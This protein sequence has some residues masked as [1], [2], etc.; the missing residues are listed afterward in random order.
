MTPTPVLVLAVA[1]FLQAPPSPTVLPPAAEHAVSAVSAVSAHPADPV[2]AIVAAFDSFR[3]VAVGENHGHREFHDLVLRLLEDSGAQAVVDDVAV[4]WGNAL[5]QP[6]VDRWVRGDDGVP[7]DSVTMAWRNTV[8]SPNTV[9]DAPVYE[10]F[11]REVRRINGSRDDGRS[12][13]V[14]LADSPVDWAAVDSAADLRPFF[15]RA[16]AMA[17][18]VRTESLR[19]GRRSLF[20]AGGLHVARVPRVRRTQQGVPVGEI[21]PVAWLELYHPGATWVVQ[22]MGAGARLDVPELVGS[23]PPA[24]V[25]LDAAP[26]LAAVVA[27]RTTTLRDR[28]GSRPDVYGALRLAD[29]VDAVLLWDPADLTFPDPDPAIWNDGW[30]WDALNR[31]SLLLRGSPMDESVRRPG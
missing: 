19:P 28:D 13:R 1:A 31:R 5:Y 22:S 25:R 23:G 26:A 7:W 18:V 14:L 15:D 3:V 10:R 4:E 2:T 12:Y 9:W 20:L 8:V 24:L 17:D 29:V 27:N 30:Y 21:T 16:R 6:V 11:F